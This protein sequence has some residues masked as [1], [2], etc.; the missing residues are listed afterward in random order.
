MAF[1]IRIPTVFLNF[2]IFFS[3]PN[4][5]PLPMMG[6]LKSA[7]TNRPSKNWKQIHLKP[8]R[9]QFE[10]EPRNASIILQHSYI[11]WTSLAGK[12]LYGDFPEPSKKK[13]NDWKRKKIWAQFKKR[14]FHNFF[15]VSYWPELTKYN[16]FVWKTKYL[17]FEKKKLKKNPTPKKKRNLM[18]SQNLSR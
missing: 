5:Q 12:S 16:D 14:I 17:N 11:F 1:S 8:S 13:K 10:I 15:F 4:A 2:D 6:Q 18:L 3:M 9:L 7:K